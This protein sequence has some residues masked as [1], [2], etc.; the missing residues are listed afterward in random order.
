VPAFQWILAQDYRW[1]LFAASFNGALARD[2]DL[3]GPVLIEDARGISLSP[4][5]IMHCLAGRRFLRAIAVF[6]RA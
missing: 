2:R 1:F 3:L 4:L 5:F 6:L